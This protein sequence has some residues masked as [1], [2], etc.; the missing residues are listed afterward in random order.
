MIL[1]SIFGEMF[2]KK[3]TGVTLHKHSR[4]LV[5]EDAKPSV[6]PSRWL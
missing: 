4:C 5:V 1:C 2:G 6:F 3:W